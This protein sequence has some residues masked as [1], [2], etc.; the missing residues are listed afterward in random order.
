MRS[1]P[2][3]SSSQS[4]TRSELAQ[5]PL[6]GGGRL[7]PEEIRQ[8]VGTVSDT[9]HWALRPKSHAG[10]ESP[11]I[12]GVESESIDELHHGCNRSAVIA[13]RG[14]CDAARR[15]TRTPALLELVVAQVVET[16]HHVRRR[17]A[18]LHDDARAHRRGGELLVDAVD[19]LPVVHR[20]NDDLAVKEIAGKFSKAVHGDSQDD[21]VCETDDLIR[22]HRTSAGSEHVDDQRNAF[23]RSRSRYRD[24]VSGTNCRMGDGRTHLAGPDDAETPL[25]RFP[26]RHWVLQ[27]PTPRGWCHPPPRQD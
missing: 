25:G 20:I 24:V 3:A 14:E 1:A 19:L 6:L 21:E 4:S 5:R 15:T 12:D 13:G 27:R 9:E 16:L 23:A 7:G 2:G 8:L 17:E 22:R 10:F 18:L 26:T 11:G